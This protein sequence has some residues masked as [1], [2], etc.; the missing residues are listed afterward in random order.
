MCECTR[1][2]CVCVCEG[3]VSVPAVLEAP[4]TGKTQPA[5]SE[6]LSLPSHP[7]LPAQ[8]VGNQRNNIS[9]LL[10]VRALLLWANPARQVSLQAAQLCTLGGGWRFG[11]PGGFPSSVGAQSR[12]ICA[13]GQGPP[14][15]VR[16]SPPRVRASPP[17]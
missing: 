13:P 11:R 1:G 12:D 5:A 16:A 7:P 8:S 14:L 17:G 9:A 15:R 6:T 4:A 10:S 3:T 2:W